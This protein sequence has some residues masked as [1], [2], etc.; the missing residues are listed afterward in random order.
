MNPDPNQTI[1][2]PNVIPNDPN[3]VNQM[4]N[5][6]MLSNPMMNGPFMNFPQPLSQ[7]QFPFNNSIPFHQQQ[8]FQQQQQN[9][10]Q[11]IMAQNSG[12]TM[13]GQMN[14]TPGNG[15]PMQQIFGHQN[16]IGKKQDT[17]RDSGNESTTMSPNNSASSL[18]NSPTSIPSRSSSF[19]IAKLTTD[20]ENISK[21]NLGEGTDNEKE[22]NVEKPVPIKEEITIHTPT[23]HRPNTS[24]TEVSNVQSSTKKD[25]VT[26]QRPKE[27]PKTTPQN[28]IQTP[29][30]CPPHHQ[31]L[32]SPM[33]QYQMYQPIHLHQNT[34]GP[35]SNQPIQ[36]PS[37]QI[38]GMFQQLPMPQYY[39]Q[40]I[41]QGHG[42]A[43]DIM[44]SSGMNE[45]CKVCGD[46]SS[47][48]HYG[49]QSC[50]GCKG[51]FRRSVQGKGN[52]Q[53]HKKNDCMVSRNTRTRCQA[54]RF[55]RCLAVGM[56]K[57]TVRG[58]KCR[59]RKAKEDDRED[60]IQETKEA[61]NISS[62][63]VEAYKEL[64]PNDI[65]FNDRNTV[66][67]KIKELLN[68]ITNF[69]DIPE[70][71]IDKLVNYGL[72][73]F[74][75]LRTVFKESDT[76]SIIGNKTMMIK[77]FKN[78]LDFETIGEECLPILSVISVC[79][80]HTPS[81]EREE[82]VDELRIKLSESLQI[83]LLAKDNVNNSFSMD[84]YTRLLYKITDLY[85]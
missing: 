56:L 26:P 35:S 81:L 60:D 10:W 46:K 4:F 65:T 54:C 70:T 59:K 63:V 78:G 20:K 77:K 5:N 50:E 49:V 57:E 62:I 9:V 15:G 24:L 48:Y 72:N 37:G 6:Q 3:F 36:P 28:N 16:G 69:D 41:Q 61:M 31:Q 7:F 75:I 76:S 67:I 55:N 33:I 64:F 12:M 53:C 74:L 19:S 40:M 73:A 42:T 21:D 83:L 38:N 39:P 82:I 13:M 85:K 11:K 18:S 34:Q 71:D 68:K 25:T 29:A 1:L 80:P 51:F 23:P 44:N 22:K 79:Q 58:E 84:M 8:H 66:M 17:D 47:G 45:L 30:S 43:I 14:L 2:Q 52:Y 27:S 32:I